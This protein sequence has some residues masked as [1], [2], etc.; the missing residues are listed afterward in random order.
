MSPP[1]CPP[2]KSKISSLEAAH[3]IYSAL[4]VM[5]MEKRRL[6][7][8]KNFK[9]EARDNA[10]S[11]LNDIQKLLRKKE[12]ASTLRRRKDKARFLR[13]NSMEREQHMVELK[14]VGIQEKQRL[15]QLLSI[16]ATQHG[17]AY[18]KPAQIKRPYFPNLFKPSQRLE[19]KNSNCTK[20]KELIQL[21]AIGS[22]NSRTNR[23]VTRSTNK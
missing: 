9:H 10:A 23:E 18:R 6:K 20:S 4:D 21:P 8:N 3:R 22:S 14:Q 16:Y 1:V 11:S 15:N 17:K 5:E 2:I 13:E 19:S 7:K 12:Y